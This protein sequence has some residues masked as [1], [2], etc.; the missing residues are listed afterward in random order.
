VKLEYLESGN[1]GRPTLL[2][3]GGGPDEVALLRKALRDM[4]EG[5]MRQLGV[6][7]LPFVQSVDDCQLR[8]TLGKTDIGVVRG[9][10]P[11]DFTWTLDAESWLWTD[12]L[13]EPFSREE[14]GIR[15]QYLNPARGSEV[16]YSTDRSW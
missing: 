6:H 8:A 16:I 7:N 2:L 4:A 1:S 11:N 3:H 5:R 10:T 9:E 14:G 15:F 13:L 12:E